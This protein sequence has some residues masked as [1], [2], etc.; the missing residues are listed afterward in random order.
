MNTS[1]K[2]IWTLYYD[3]SAASG[4]TISLRSF[5]AWA[6]MEEQAAGAVSRQ[7][8]RSGM[9]LTV[10]CQFCQTDHLR[11]SGEK[12]N[13]HSVRSYGFAYAWR[14]YPQLQFVRKMRH[15]GAKRVGTPKE[16]CGLPRIQLERNL[17]LHFSF[18]GDFFTASIAAA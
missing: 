8:L 17:S 9:L 7:R 2:M 6:H 16:H 14:S 18:S 10:C 12:G 11:L 13:A 5:I 1:V 3:S 4:C 15:Q